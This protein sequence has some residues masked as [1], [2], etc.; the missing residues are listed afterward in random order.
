L[1]GNYKLSKDIFT[2][3][4]LVEIKEECRI[5][6]RCKHPQ[7]IHLIN[8]IINSKTASLQTGRRI[9]SPNREKRRDS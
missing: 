7:I 1:K 6:G 4:I 9:I 3:E 8:T 5:L 2:K